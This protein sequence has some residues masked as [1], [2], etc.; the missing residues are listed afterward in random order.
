MIKALPLLL[1]I[2]FST[3]IALAQNYQLE[4]KLQSDKN[5]D[6]IFLFFSDNGNT[7]Y[8]PY[9]AFHLT[10]LSSTYAELYTQDLSDNKL[11]I[12]SLPFELE[13]ILEIPVYI[14]STFAD[15]FNITIPKYQDFPQNWTLS[16]IDTTETDTVILNTSS[17][18][19]IIHE[20]NLE[21]GVLTVKHFTLLV[22]PGIE[23]KSISIPGTS[24]KNGWRFLGSPFSNISYTSL[25][26]SIWTQGASGSDDSTASPTIFTW[27]ESQQEFESISNLDQTPEHG[28]GFIAYIYEDDIPS[29]GAVDGGWPKVFQT[30]GITNFG[31]IKFPVSYK[32]GAD[33]SLNGYNLI[34]NPYPFSIDW[35][36][37]S[38]W[39]R[40]NIQDAIWIWDPNQ[41]NGN[42]N[43]L[44]Y[45]DGIGDDISE[46]AP[47]QA[48]WVRATASNPSIIVTEDIASSVSA[49]LLKDE[50]VTTEYLRVSVS[51]DTFSDQLYFRFNDSHDRSSIAELAPISDQFLS[52][53][54]K[55]KEGNIAIQNLP[56]EIEEVVFPLTIESSS[57][58][59]A[60]ITIEHIGGIDETYTFELLDDDIK[61]TTSISE[62]ETY[63]FVLNTN[64]KTF[65]LFIRNQTVV[66]SEN[67]IDIPSKVSLYQNYPNPFNPSTTISFSLHEVGHV[68]LEVFDI[69]GRKIST[70]VNGVLSTGFYD[71]TFNSDELSSGIYMYRI[72]TNEEILTKRMTLL[73]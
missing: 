8:D 62:S 25:L 48:F 47:F 33:S 22:N 36:A 39:S 58:G 56:I 41:N 13:E 73:K 43:Y 67:P 60:T 66:K 44:V 42:G 1:I 45:S 18:L 35:N 9:D 71:V 68:T 46:I 64:H 70:L 72:K 27:N 49:S 24:G 14:T 31:E 28:M 63:K 34:S 54:T 65:K 3:K 19:E 15:T 16:L 21:S 5:S 26:D 23:T 59:L 53:Y 20:G 37:I 50:R 11:S 52:L 51:L 38:G 17:S 40:T 6:R 30:T 61:K 69:K 12:N 4:L 29:T 10:S 55:S 32:S 57:T 2:F 7:G